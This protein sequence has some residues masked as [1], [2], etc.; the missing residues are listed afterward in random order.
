MLRLLALH[1]SQ[2][3]EVQGHPLVLTKV[4]LASPLR[5]FEASALRFFLF[6]CCP[7]T[8]TGTRTEFEALLLVLFTW[9]P[10]S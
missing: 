5:S 3:D 1:I 9:A 2:V 7:E 4:G 6:Q 8:S 10:K